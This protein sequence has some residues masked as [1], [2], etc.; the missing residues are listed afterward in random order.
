[1]AGTLELP[2]GVFG[3]NGPQRLPHSRAALETWPHAQLKY[4]HHTSELKKAYIIYWG[5]Q[6]P[7]LLSC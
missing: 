7:L 5:F 2:A 6:R 4:L 1:M 3:V